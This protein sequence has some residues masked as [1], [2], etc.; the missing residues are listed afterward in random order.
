LTPLF[1]KGSEGAKL[2]EKE[3]LRNAMSERRSRKD[4]E[5]II[6]SGGSSN[7]FQSEESKVTKETAEADQIFNFE[8][9]YAAYE[10]EE[11]EKEMDRAWYDAD[12]NHAGYGMDDYYEKFLGDQDKYRAFEQELEKKKKQEQ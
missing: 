1:F 8:D 3:P 11:E 9:N 6:M 7:K 2:I 10:W 12:E 4:E 5:A